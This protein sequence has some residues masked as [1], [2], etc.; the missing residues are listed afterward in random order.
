VHHQP[1]RFVR[2]FAP[3]CWDECQRPERGAGSGDGS[4]ELKSSQRTAGRDGDGHA[5]SHEQLAGVSP[6]DGGLWGLCSVGCTWL[7]RAFDSERNA[8]PEPAGEGGKSGRRQE[9]LGKAHSRFSAADGRPLLRAGCLQWM[10]LSR[11]IGT[12]RF[13]FIF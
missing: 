7:L 10:V 5:G 13:L 1:P 11:E 4:S 3:F 2:R 8:E 9:G 12:N 6:G